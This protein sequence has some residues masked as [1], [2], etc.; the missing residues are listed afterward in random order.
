MTGSHWLKGLA[1]GSVLLF[2]GLTGYTL[3][4]MLDLQHDLSEDLGENMVWAASQAAYQ[5]SLLQQAHIAPGAVAGHRGNPVLQRALL[6]G[7]LEVLLAPSQTVFMKEAGVL[8]QLLQ[9]KAMV[10]SNKPD[11]ALVQTMLHDLGRQIMQTE[12]EQSGERRDA[13][14]RLLRQL[15]FFIYCVMASGGV[16][17]WQL[18]RSLKHTREALEEGARQNAQARELLDALETE[19][20]TRLRYRDFVSVMSH[21]LRTPLA[22]IDSSAQRLL[23]QDNSVELEQSVAA[24]SQRIRRS[25][26][27][28]NQLIARVL[29]GLRLGE[30][31]ASKG[32]ELEIVRCDWLEVVGLSLDSFGDLLA[33]RRVN[34]HV[35]PGTPQPLWIECDRMWCAEILSNLISNADKYSPPD[36]DIDIRIDSADGMLRCQVLN[37]GAGIS[38]QDMERL[39]ERFF[40]GSN[41]H[42]S[43]GVGLGL[44]I[45]Q[46]LTHWHHG[47]LTASNR[48]EG[49]ACFT[50]QLPLHWQS[51][52]TK[53]I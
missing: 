52:P 16:L 17:C 41:G 34:L 51:S 53:A 8:E 31:S 2:I 42:R 15:I 11:F 18:L 22:V 50:L 36:S 23:R 28:L 49:G 7:R 26:R 35:A 48:S 33:E 20:A 9:V 47:S 12:R 10:Y 43:A 44:S 25:V 27:Q 21:Q 14:K 40:R 30:Q 37:G 45:A 29:Q 3:R 24:R 39:F 6:R 13:Y 46:T 38:E 32:I 5:S 4:A 1:F 19:R